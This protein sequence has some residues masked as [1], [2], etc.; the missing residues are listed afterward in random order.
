MQENDAHAGLLA[1]LAQLAPIGEDVSDEHLQARV[2]EL[3]H[4]SEYKPMVA[5]RR[6]L[7]LPCIYLS[8]SEYLLPFIAGETSFGCIFY[9]GVCKDANT[10]FVYRYSFMIGSTEV[11]VIGLTFVIA[12]G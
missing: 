1:V 3:V 12:C 4:K 9:L 5:E 11:A 6:V 8:F 2:Q 7:S 10:V